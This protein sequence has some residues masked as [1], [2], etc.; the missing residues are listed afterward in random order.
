[1]ALSRYLTRWIDVPHEPG[2]R[3]QFRMPNWTIVE[4]A[5][6]ERRR[7]LYVDMR[8]TR[9]VV[10]ADILAEWRKEQAET[11]AADETTAVAKL[12]TAEERL[13]EFDQQLLLKAGIG[14]WT[15]CEPLLDDDDNPL[16]DAEGHPRPDRHKPIKVTVDAIADLDPVTQKWAGLTL[17]AL[18][19][20]G[21]RPIMPEPVENER[22]DIIDVRPGEDSAPFGRSS[23]Y[24]GISMARA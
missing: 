11:A 19:N 14:A 12:P 18:I 23:S 8:E 16:L 1:M 9:E 7:K 10:G 21:F 6:A 2:E 3:F 15:Y 20:S 22:G 24:D 13:N 4:D 5:R 17:I